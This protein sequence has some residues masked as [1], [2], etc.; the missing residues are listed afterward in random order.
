MS[1]PSH[2][3]KTNSKPFFG[4]TMI[5]SESPSINVKYN[6]V[7]DFINILMHSFPSLTY[8]YPLFPTVHF[9]AHLIGC[10]VF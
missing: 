8:Q 3:T 4:S 9:I 5:K 10:A 7:Y 2:P 6:E 1:L